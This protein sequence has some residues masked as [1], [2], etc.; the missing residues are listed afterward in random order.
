MN[1]GMNREKQRLETA[2]NRKK[3]TEIENR[4]KSVNRLP[5]TIYRRSFLTDMVKTGTKL[6]K[7]F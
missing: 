1:R 3:R 2:E 4:S 5:L 7:S 6:H